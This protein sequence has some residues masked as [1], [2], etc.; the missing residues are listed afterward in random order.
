MRKILVT[1]GAGYI[2]SHTVKILGEKGNK[3]YVLDNLSTGFEDSVLCGKLYKVDLLEKAKVNKVFEEITPDAII[4]FAAKIFAPESIKKPLKYYENN[5]IGLINLLEA[6]NKFGIKKVIFSS[7]AFVYGNPKKIPISE[8]SPIDPITPYGQSKAM[9]ERIL[10]DFSM[11]SGLDYVVLRYFNVAGA[12]PEGKLG[13]RKKNATHLITQ[14]TRVACGHLPELKIFGTDY[15]TRD[16]TCIR[17]YIHV[18]DLA[19]AHI[20]ALEYLFNEGKKDIF[21]CGYGKG[22]SVKEV[23]D[24]VKRVTGVDFPVTEASRREEDPAELVAETSKI[25]EVLGWEPKFDSLDY[26]VETAA[27]WE[28]TG[29]KNK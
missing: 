8:D 11:P 28:K 5:L 21:N 1:G 3:V 16:G 26:I 17:D 12:D 24:S 23:V 6:A 25:K 4:H 9:G 22:F 19:N 18:T 10:R 29:L 27:N 15:N 13:E 2:G 7:S 20:C 14:A